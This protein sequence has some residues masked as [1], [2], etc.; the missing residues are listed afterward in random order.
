MS[1]GT[2]YIIRKRFTINKTDIPVICRVCGKTIAAGSKCHVVVRVSPVYREFDSDQDEMTDFDEGDFSVSVK[3]GQSPQVKV[4]LPRENALGRATDYV[5]EPDV[6][7][8]HFKGCGVSPRKNA[9]RVPGNA[10]GG[11][12]HRGGNFK[13]RK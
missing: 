12:K 3:R 1:E 7:F 10:G 13:P 8:H 11:K 6:A 9:R 4:G 2:R 5:L